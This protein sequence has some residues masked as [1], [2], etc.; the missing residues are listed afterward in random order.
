[1]C[2]GSLLGLEH[3]L[4][5][6]V[7]AFEFAVADGDRAVVGEPPV[8][9]LARDADHVREHAAPSWFRAS[10]DPHLGPALRE[11]HANPGHPWTV[12]VT[13]STRV[14]LARER[15]RDSSDGIAAIAQSLGCASEFSFAAAF[16]RHEGI[17]PGRW[18]NHA[19]AAGP[20]HDMQSGSPGSS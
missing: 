6:E 9:R 5:Q 15:L 2:C 10:S 19:R 16:K 20:R 13:G 11:V 8:V 18:R 14:A 4:A 1:V 12:R 3:D 17:A 7:A